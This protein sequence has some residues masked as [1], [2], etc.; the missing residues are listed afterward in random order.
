MKRYL[1]ID[2]FKIS[3]DS[4]K[5]PIIPRINNIK[6]KIINIQLKENSYIYR[7]INN[8]NNTL[9][10]KNSYNSD[11]KSNYL[12][13]SYRNYKNKTADKFKFN[14][15]SNNKICK[16]SSSKNSEINSYNYIS[17]KSF[18]FNNIKKR[19][20]ADS[21]NMKFKN[22][23]NND[24]DKDNEIFYDKG[25]MIFMKPLNCIN[26]N[27]RK[28]INNTIIEKKGL[29]LYKNHSGT[30]NCIRN[31]DNNINTK[32]MKIILRNNFKKFKKK[33]FF[34]SNN[35]NCDD[36]DK[37]HLYYYEPIGKSIS[38]LYIKNKKSFNSINCRI[39]FPYFVTDKELMNNYSYNNFCNFRKWIETY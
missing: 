11:L 27:I 19:N 25:N 1:T 4:Y 7:N 17:K 6:S 26:S 33:K 2:K 31:N 34:H 16:K 36:K 18:S 29:L 39:C 28:N 3:N 15:L 13:L 5:E 12:S 8:T 22:I 20:Y 38:E 10:T 37:S 9:S 30:N 23:F 35:N 14:N 32:K 21:L 24:N